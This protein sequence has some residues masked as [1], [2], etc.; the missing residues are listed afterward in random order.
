MTEAARRLAPCRRTSAT[1]DGRRDGV[2]E[3]SE[4]DLLANRATALGQL[5]EDRLPLERDSNGPETAWPLVGP[6]LLAQATGSLNS[7][8]LLRPHG[9][10]NDASRL[11]RS[12]YDH[13]VTFAW[14]A[15]DPPGRLGPWRK[16]DLLER[17]KMARE[18]DAVG[19][20]LMPAAVREQMEHDVKHIEGSVPGLAD[21]ARDADEHWLPR[22]TGDL[23]GTGFNSFRGL[24]TVL[25]RNHSGLVHA[26]MS[27]LNHVTIDLNL[28]RRRVVRQAPLDGSRGPYGMATVI[29]GLGLLVAAQSLGWPAATHVRVVFERTQ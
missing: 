17:L 13:V 3:L 10:H 8:F 29:H 19:V 14:L 21:M 16:A 5:V 24:Y 12:L 18:F 23:D 2:T 7:I 22:L 28:P 6:A 1:D 15:V 11:L 9:A 26:T 25:F 20:E 27:G 4:Y